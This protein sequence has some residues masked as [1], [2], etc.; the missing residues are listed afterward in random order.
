VAIVK[1]DLARSRARKA[2]R[3]EKALE[4]AYIADALAGHDSKALESTGNATPRH[5]GSRDATFPINQPKRPRKAKRGK[6]KRAPSRK[7]QID[8]IKKR[9]LG[10]GGKWS[11]AVRARDGKCVMCHK[12]DTLQ[13]HHW[14]FRRGHSMALA[15]D[16][17]NGAT[18]CYGCHIGRVH[19]DGDGDFIF[20]LG[21]TMTAKVG[22]EKV[23]EMR[24]TA[25]TS[26][27][28][29]LEWWQEKEAGFDGA[30]P[31]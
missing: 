4:S 11:K 15:V 8:G 21:D 23:A 19:H 27:P 7:K 20:R 28:L 10:V 25:Q 29:S 6:L 3:V 18:L 17:A 1:T 9:I 2:R 24:I 13:A 26:Q 31:M 5:W 12:T 30:V 22:P 16:I 14:L